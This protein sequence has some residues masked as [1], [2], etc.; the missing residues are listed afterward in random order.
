MNTIFMENEILGLLVYVNVLKKKKKMK[1]KKIF[2][3][4]FTPVSFDSPN[5]SGHIAHLFNYLKVG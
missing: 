1:E 4:H 2:V 3:V 5:A